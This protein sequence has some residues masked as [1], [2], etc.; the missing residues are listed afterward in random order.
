MKEEVKVALCIVKV[1][2]RIQVQ[3]LRILLIHLHLRHFR[4][5][6][7]RRKTMEAKK[8]TLSTTRILKVIRKSTS[9]L[10]KVVRNYCLVR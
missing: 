10:L 1:Y 6:K 9:K 3:F 7:R 5:I 8:L 2:K 4:R